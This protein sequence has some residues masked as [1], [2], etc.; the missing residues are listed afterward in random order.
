MSAVEFSAVL[1]SHEVH[2][3]EM[4]LSQQVRRSHFMGHW[5][6]GTVGSPR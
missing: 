5:K 4:A 1:Q 3:T 2:S 6:S